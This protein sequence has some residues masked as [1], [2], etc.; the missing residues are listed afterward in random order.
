MA[1][2]NISKLFSSSYAEAREKFLGA[3]S[4]RGLSVDSYEL[5]LRGADGER[6]ATDVVLD[7]PSDASNLLIVISGCHGVEGYC[8]SAIQTGL[9]ELDP[10]A[11]APFD[12]RSA[13]VLHV[14]A[15][16]PYGFSHTRRA[17]QENVDLNRNFVDFSTTLPDNAG[18]AE[19]HDLLLPRDWPPQNAN[20]ILLN[21][22]RERVGVRG[23]QRAVAL[24]Q[25]A[26]ED[27]LHFGGVAPTWSNS[28]F[29]SILRKYAVGSRHIGS[30]DIHTG[31]G[32]YGV[33]ERIFAAPDNPVT[34]ARSRQWWG[35]NMTSVATGTSVSIPLSGPIQAALSEE[36]P[37]AAQT[38]VCL[39]FGTYAMDEVVH[40]MR[41]EHW[42]HR[43]GCTDNAKRNTIKA[44]LK[45]A[46][47]PE[48]DDWK[49]AVWVQGREVY[50]QALN[51]LQRGLLP[52]LGNHEPLA[53]GAVEQNNIG[54]LR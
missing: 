26:F 5:P 43:Y 45:R 29:R 7:G 11:K 32:P 31:L 23:F 24:G 50:L 8:G 38:N 9:L 42:L 36:C 48:H 21:A 33:G 1:Q 47:Y 10:G 14:H 27:G 2:Q 25:Y 39:E 54:D 41:A 35:D 6:L 28:T 16:N 52:E 34:L 51:G 22:Y 15:V 53:R 49:L 4:R 44:A 17:T 40:A 37:D 18:Y 12:A 13:A 3:A 30:I 20:E 46:F 19:I